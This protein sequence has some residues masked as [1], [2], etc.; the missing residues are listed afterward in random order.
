LLQI[1][2]EGLGGVW[3]GFYPDKRIEKV[4]EYFNLPEHIIPFSVIPFGYGKQENGF[5]DRYD[6][7]KVHYETMS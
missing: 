6:V 2:A 1:A 3:L 4:K 5:V 7:N